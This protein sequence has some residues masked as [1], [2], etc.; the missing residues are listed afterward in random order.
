MVGGQCAEGEE[1]VK[2]YSHLYQVYWHTR[3]DGDSCPLYRET[4]EE[5]LG[6][7]RRRMTLLEEAQWPWKRPLFRTAAVFVM[8]Q[9]DATTVAWW[10]MVQPGVWI[11]RVNPVKFL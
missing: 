3:S 7:A 5:A 8:R 1:A 4:L 11:V 9:P 10:E 6:Q 2:I